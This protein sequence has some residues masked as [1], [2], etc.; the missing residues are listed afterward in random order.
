MKLRELSFEEF[1]LEIGADEDD[2][3]EMEKFYRKNSRR[4]ANIAIRVAR[5]YVH[6]KFRDV[7]IIVGMGSTRYNWDYV[8]VYS[9]VTKQIRPI[10]FN[11][12]MEE[13][14]L[15]C[16]SM[17]EY[18]GSVNR[19]RIIP[20]FVKK[21]DC[22]DEEIAELILSGI[23]DVE[24]MEKGRNHLIFPK[25]KF[26][27]ESLIDWE[28]YDEDVSIEDTPKKPIVDGNRVNFSLI[29]EDVNG[30]VVNIDFISI[31]FRFVS[32]LAE[33]ETLA[34]IEDVLSNGEYV[35]CVY[36]RDRE[37]KDNPIIVL[38]EDGNIDHCFYSLSGNGIMEVKR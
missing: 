20:R 31:R 27:A 32:P 37:D 16:P 5:E 29:F 12:V 28:Q 11:G 4:N 6:Q 24:D 1:L 15:K 10:V 35:F 25:G 19:G 7:G 3:P 17:I 9:P 18:K 22:A 2:V 34:E 21:I 33:I 26:R 38:D 8:E 36:M 14:D 23:V 13:A 30:N